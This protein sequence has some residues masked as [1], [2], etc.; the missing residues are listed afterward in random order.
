MLYGL[1][2]GFPFLWAVNAV[3]SDVFGGL[4]VQDFSSVAIEHRDDVAAEVSFERG[5]GEKDVQHYDQ[6]IGIVCDAS[7]LVTP[8]RTKWSRGSVGRQHR[9]PGGSFILLVPHTFV[10]M[11]TPRVVL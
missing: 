7:R 1:A 2:L 11:T 4:V 3:E 5:T 6:T 8:G 10:G 9:E